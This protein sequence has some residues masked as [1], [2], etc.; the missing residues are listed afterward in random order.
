MGHAG[1]GDQQA[2]QVEHVGE[3]QALE[4]VRQVTR[5]RRLQTERGY[6]RH[7]SERTQEQALYVHGLFPGPSI[8]GHL[9]EKVPDSVY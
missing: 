9:Q 8:Q 2:Q 1:V 3:G 6:G 5:V 7:V 4:Q